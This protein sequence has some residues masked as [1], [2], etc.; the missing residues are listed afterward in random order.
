MAGLDGHGWP[1]TSSRTVPAAAN[2]FA[3]ILLVTLI[4]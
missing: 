1:V 2:C 4:K 3:D